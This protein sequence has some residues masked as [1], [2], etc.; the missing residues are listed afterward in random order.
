MLS[1]SAIL[2]VIGSITVGAIAM[3]ISTA[4]GHDSNIEPETYIRYA[5]LLTLGVYIVV[6]TLIVTQLVPGVRL[7]WS[8][9]SPGGGIAF[10]ALIGGG[11][12]A[13]LLAA[14]TAAAGHLSPDPRM[15]TTMSEG[16]V[17]HIV[18]TLAIAC[19]CAP[20]VEEVLFRGLLLESLRRRSTVLAIA[21]SS[22][23]FAV[24]HLNPAALRYYALIGVLLGIL[25]VKR[26]LVCSM[27]AHFTFNAVLGVAALA[28]VLAPTTTYDVGAVSFAAPG[29][30][31]LQHQQGDSVL[32]GGPSGAELFVLDRASSHRVDTATLLQRLRNGGLDSA[33]PGLQVN[34]DTIRQ[35]KLAAGNA[36]EVDVTTEGH[37]GTVVLM[38]LARE[39]VE[40]LF[41]NAGSAKAESQFQRILQSLRVA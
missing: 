3:G 10:G 24:W 36:V 7:R 13:A 5:I 8:K 33:V 38:P 15:V 14:V 23:G 1:T 31:S 18:V 41:L 11:V 28:V 37:G 30:W 40:V 32:L 25:Y 35:Q 4:L 29:G 12:S 26:G 16:D 17:P 19:L 21:V 27:A 20:L 22:A 2:L 39:S 6:G 9:G 34:Q